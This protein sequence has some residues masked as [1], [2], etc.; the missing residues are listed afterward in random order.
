MLTKNSFLKYFR[1]KKSKKSPLDDFYSFKNTKLLRTALNHKSS[2]DKTCDDNEKLEFLGDAVLGLIVSD[3][4]MSAYPEKNEGFLTKTRSGLVSGAT[5]TEVGRKAGI[6]L[7][8][9]TGHKSDME[10]PRL[11]AEALEAFFGAVYLDGGFIA[12]KKVIQ[13]LFEEK[14]HTKDFTPDYKSLLQEWCQKNHKTPPVYRVR[15]TEGPEHEKIFYM[16]VVLKDRLLGTGCN[17]RKKEAEQLAAKN[18]LIK[19]EI[20]FNKI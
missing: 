19:L 4:L 9:N 15:K 2:Y 1:L 14:I 12:A 16:E 20:S 6:P 18:A 10:N 3:L 7:Y 8:L 11:I 17:N 13:R 5:L